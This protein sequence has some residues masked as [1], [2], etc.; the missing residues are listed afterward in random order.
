MDGQ[1]REVVLYRFV[2]TEHVAWVLQLLCGK[3]LGRKIYSN[4]ELNS[5]GFIKGTF[6][7]EKIGIKFT[8]FF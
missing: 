7:Y 2:D 4:D 1:C 8:P 6:P 5:W 3:V